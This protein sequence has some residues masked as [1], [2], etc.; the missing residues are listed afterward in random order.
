MCKKNI[1]GQNTSIFN[2]VVNFIVG[3]ETARHG[4]F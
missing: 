2:D 3:I 1:V 4:I